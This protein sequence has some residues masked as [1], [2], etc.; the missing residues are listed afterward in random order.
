MLDSESKLVKFVVGELELISYRQRGLRILTFVSLLISFVLM[1]F[2]LFFVK[3][4]VVVT[5]INI[6]IISIFSILFYLV[7]FKL[8]HSVGTILYIITTLILV[9]SIWFLFDD[10]TGS[11]VVSILV[12]STI[13]TFISPKKFFWP[14]ITLSVVNLLALIVISQQV[15]FTFIYINDEHKI[16]DFIVISVVGILVLNITIHYHLVLYAK[17]VAEIKANN[18]YLESAREVLKKNNEELLLLNGQLIT[19]EER[20][21]N[22]MHSKSNFL[23]VMSHEI[24]T[25]L[26]AIVGFAGFIKEIDSDEKEVRSSV[27]NIYFSSQ[28][29]LL[30]INDILDFNKIDEGKLMLKKSPFNMGRILDLL[31]SMYR[32]IIEEKGLSFVYE[33]SA[34][35]DDKLF[36]GDET[37]LN[38]V[39][40]NLMSN[41]AKFTNSGKIYL[42]CTVK[43]KEEKFWTINIKISDTGIGISEDNIDLIFK[44]FTQVDSDTSRKHQGSG[45]GLTIT[46]SLIE[47]FDSEIK[48]ESVLGKGSTFSFDVKLPVVDKNLNEGSNEDSIEILK[49]KTILVADDNAFNRVVAKNFLKRWGLEV[50]EAKNGREAFDFVLG[51]NCDIIL[52]DLHMPEMDGF[53]ATRFIRKLNDLLKSQI[54]IIALSADVMDETILKVKESGMNDYISKPFKPEELK[55]KILK[56]SVLNLQNLSSSN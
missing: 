29:L 46:K 54:P 9:D 22:A 53:E 14:L 8:S 37:R 45:L 10:F 25:P 28:H 39:L 48:V 35:I 18:K 50:V 19:E 36:V 16:I 43:L 27:K 23:S 32:G 15:D 17:K 7:R 41:A 34:D 55:Q 24:R 40:I 2:N 56:F 26:N 21:R 3:L 49:G 4:G 42:G 6:G 52:M 31:E 20:S 5:F 51:N 47:L 38:Q 1:F 33:K 44:R 12:L 13:Y 11:Q 30:L